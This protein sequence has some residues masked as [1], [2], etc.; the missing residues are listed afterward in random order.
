[1][2]KYLLTFLFLCGIATVVGST[3]RN[4]LI[5]NL[6]PFTL[7]GEINSLNFM[8]QKSKFTVQIP[9][10]G[11]LEASQATPISVPNVRTGGL[12]VFWIIKDGSTVKKGDTLIE[13][14][15]SELLQQLDETNSNLAATLHQLEA[16]VLRGSSDTEQTVTDRDIA[17]MELEKAHTQA[18][19]DAEIFSHHQIIEDSLKEELSQTKVTEWTGKIETRKNIS[20]TA[21]RILVIDKNRHNTKKDLLEGSLGSLKIL[22][23]HD[24]LVLHQKDQIG[25]STSIGETRWPGYI[26]LTLPKLSSIKARVYVLESDAGGLKAGL[27]TRISVDSHPQIKFEATVERIDTLTR[28][29]NKDSPVKYLEVILKISVTNEEILKPGKSVHADIITT[30]YQEALVVP[31]VAI[32]EEALK[33]YVWVKGVNTLEKREVKLGVGDS[34]RVAVVSGLQEGESILLNPPSSNT[35]NKKKR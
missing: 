10:W 22:A 23:P 11:E 17:E 24:S 31:R 26:L 13:F 34:A 29:R 25:R 32:I 1:M 8:V 35:L 4:R 30:Q 6:N 19:K 9:A 14:D 20:T 7:N 12:K 16:T 5:T 15:A 2:K 33:Y 27:P 18:A 21:Q 28:Q 3:Y